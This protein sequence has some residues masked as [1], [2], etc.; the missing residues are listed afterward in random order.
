MGPELRG[1]LR[2]SG[3]DR[4][5]RPG[6]SER[7][8]RCVVGRRD[9]RVQLPGGFPSC[10]P[11]GRRRSGE[12]QARSHRRGRNAPQDRSPGR[13]P[14]S[15]ALRRG[16]R[17]AD[18][19][20]RGRNVRRR[21]WPGRIVRRR[22]VGRAPVRSHGKNAPSARW[23]SH[24]R[25]IPPSDPHSMVRAPMIGDERGGRK[26]E[27]LRESAAQRCRAPAGHR[28]VSV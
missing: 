6:R 7:S 28:A 27:P 2:S 25:G 24:R 26:L 10:R 22:Q 21:R 16:P 5:H 12:P 23:R 9:R 19:R 14:D 3:A 13:K 4:A 17:S 18:S 15:D 8:V 1:P 20:R 11:P